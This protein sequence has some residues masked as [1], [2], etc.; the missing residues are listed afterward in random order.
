MRNSVIFFLFLFFGNAALRAQAGCTL[1]YPLDAKV[2]LEYTYYDKNGNME[3]KTRSSV[4]AVR[5]LPG[6]VEA[7]I[8]NR[9]FDKRDKEQ[10][11]GEYRVRC[12]GG[13][14]KMDA[15]SMLNP[16]MQ[17]S[18]SNMDVDVEGEAFVIPGKMKPGQALPDAK[19][20]IRAAAKGINIVDMTV[21]VTDRK[22]AGQERV[23]TPAGTFDCYKISQTTEVRMMLAK[24]F[25]SVEYYAE[26]VGLV[27]SETYDQQGNLEGYMEL[28]AFGK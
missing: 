19:T 18:L 16:G 27:R 21:T 12:E 8:F 15:T 24:S 11:T 25:A 10:F 22:V 6:G 28:T 23:T 17:Q 26:G 5:S 2:K 4:K 9:I 7:V 14:I 20:N 13:L 1:F 3:S